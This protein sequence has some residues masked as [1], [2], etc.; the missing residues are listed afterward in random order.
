ML[1]GLKRDEK[2]TKKDRNRD[3]ELGV[4][5]RMCG[6]INL[7]CLKVFFFFEGRFNILLFSLAGINQNF[8]TFL[9]C[10]KHFFN[11][12]IQLEKRFMAY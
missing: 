12:H 11:S 8:M 10:H 7:I 9:A 2:C 1:R 6:F 4:K 3:K 5:M